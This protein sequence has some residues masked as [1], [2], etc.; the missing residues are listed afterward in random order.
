MISFSPPYAP[1]AKEYNLTY[2]A[3]DHGFSGPVNSSL[4]SFVS[5]AQ[6][7]WT[8]S[9]HKL[10]FPILKDGV[11]SFIR[12]SALPT[13]PP[14]SLVLSCSVGWWRSRWRLVLPDQ[15]QQLDQDSL[16]RSKRKE[17]EPL[18]P[19][20]HTNHAPHFQAYY[21]PFAS[22]KN[23]KVLTSAFASKIISTSTS[24]GV[25]ATAVQYYVNGTE[26]TATLAKG[27][28]VIVSAG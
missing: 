5:P 10:G 13:N 18:C 22:R 21:Q 19:S 4:P 2:I 24:N 17:R 12:C 20:T 1:Y 3:A 25:S 7:P 9:L 26:F 16:V 28:E 27:G 14:V 8:D 15:H 11:S 6:F 23:L